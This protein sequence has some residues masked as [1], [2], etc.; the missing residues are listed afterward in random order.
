MKENKDLTAIK[1]LIRESQHGNGAAANRLANFLKSKKEKELQANAASGEK[2]QYAEK[3]RLPSATE[4][5]KLDKLE[6]QGDSWERDYK[7][8]FG[9]SDKKAASDKKGAKRRRSARDVQ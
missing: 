1:P 8:R 9:F 6:S 7:L 5:K 3:A 2:S 4:K